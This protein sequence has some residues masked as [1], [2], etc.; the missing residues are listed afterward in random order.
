MIHWRLKP[1][2]VWARVFFPP[3][4]RGAPFLVLFLLIFLPEHRLGKEKKPKPEKPSVQYALIKGS[5]FREDGFSLRGAR[6]VCRRTADAKPHGETISGE[7]GEFAFRVPVGKAQYEITAEARGFEPATRIVEIQQD[8]R[9]DISI[10]L[11]S[12]TP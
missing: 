5:V 7:G 12:K 11:K 6:V 10:V 9:R 4:L 8:E 2:G 3:L 1:R